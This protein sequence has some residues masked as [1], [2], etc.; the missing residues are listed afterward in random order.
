MRGAEFDRIQANS[1]DNGAKIS[2]NEYNKYSK[3]ISKIVAARLLN[4]EIHNE[5]KMNMKKTN[6]KSPMKRIAASAT[7][8]ATSAAMLGTSTYAWFT[9]NKT[10]TVTGMEMKTQVGANLLISDCNIES[11][12]STAALSQGRAALLEPVSSKTGANDS[13][14][15]TVDALG[16]GD[17]M[18]DNVYSQYK[19]DTGATALQ[20]GAIDLITVTSGKPSTSGAGIAKGYLN[21]LYQGIWC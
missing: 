12:Y 14:W 10:V 17:A 4:A 16:N 8:L 11:D 21:N 19:E 1:L 9:M 6:N 18:A 13:F 2:Y 20:T 7:M 5:R 15:Y 3:T